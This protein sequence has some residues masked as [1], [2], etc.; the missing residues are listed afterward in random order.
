MVRPRSFS[1][2]TSFLNATV[3]RLSISANSGARRPGQAAMSRSVRRV[4][5]PR[6]LRPS[7]ASSRSITVAMAVGLTSSRNAIRESTPSKRNVT[8]YGR[9]VSSGF[10]VR[11]R[12]AGCLFADGPAARGMRLSLT[13]STVANPARRASSAVTLA[14]SERSISSTLKIISSPTTV[15]SL[16]P[17]LTVGLR[18][19]RNCI[20]M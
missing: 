10:A 3:S 12:A 2:R 8:R 11:E 9:L 17:A 4:H 19:R 5:G 15:R 13:S 1:R 18:H 20:S 16:P 6:E 7:M 14:G